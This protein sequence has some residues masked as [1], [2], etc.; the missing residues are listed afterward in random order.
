MER[1]LEI[2]FTICGI[3]IY[4]P[5]EGTSLSVAMREDEY[6]GKHLS[7]CIHLQYRVSVAPD[8]AL[9]EQEYI[10]RVLLEEGHLLL[11][12]LSLLLNRPSWLLVHKARL[13]GV[14]VKLRLPPQDFPLG[15]YNVVAMW[16]RPL[17]TI[18]YSSVVHNGGWPLLETLVS[19]FRQKPT[20]LRKMLTLPLRWF[21]KAADEMASL[22][23][24][25]AF[26]I[27]FNALYAD[28]DK[29]EQAAIK[30]YIKS[31]VDSFIAQ[32]YIDSNE[33][34]LLTLSSF[35]IELGRGKKRP[36]AQELAQSLKADPRNYANIV[37]TTALTI[38]AIR[39]A[40]FHG[41]CDP[42]SEDDQRHIGVAERLLSR[43]VR[44]LIAKQMLGYPLPTTRFITQEKAF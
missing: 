23:R 32:R 29:L 36:I 26:W 28:P 25:V 42:Y 34:L 2:D 37:E 40:L 8:T 11:Q 14:D 43:L 17:T 6:Q 7:N 20:K 12:S 27:S 15:L 35:P 10:N 3:E 21:T 1:I 13:D 4:Q 31:N 24:L 33:Q 9:S 44:E 19:E 38:Y 41:E 22:D 39:C 18:R 16:D 5:Y 30:S